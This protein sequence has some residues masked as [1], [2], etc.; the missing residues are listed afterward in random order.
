MP[1]DFDLDGVLDKRDLKRLRERIRKITEP[2][3]L[4]RKALKVASIRLVELVR[5][6]IIQGGLH[7][8][9]GTPGFWPPTVAGNDPLQNTGAFLASINYV[10]QGQG[11][12]LQS[13]V[14]TNLPYVKYHEQPG[15]KLG[16][17]EYSPTLK[18]RWFLFFKFG[19][20]IRE[21]TKIRIPQRRTFVTPRT[22][23]KAVIEAYRE[24]LLSGA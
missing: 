2:S 21:G 5:N 19:W 16:Y 6:G 11:E 9:S 1:N 4:H 18:Q 17:I 20:R 8:E 22:V 14:G 3:E 23:R 12:D 13:V 24:A 7:P 15:N 10:I